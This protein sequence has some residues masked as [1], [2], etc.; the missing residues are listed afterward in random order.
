MPLTA[1]HCVCYRYE[2]SAAAAIFTLLE[3]ARNTHD[4]AGVEGAIWCLA[5]LSHLCGGRSLRLHAPHHEQLLFDTLNAAATPQTT[6][7]ILLA[8]S[9]LRAAAADPLSVRRVARQLKRVQE[10]F[11]SDNNDVALLAC[12]VVANVEQYSP[13]AHTMPTAQCALSTQCR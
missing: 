12:A 13:G 10:L 9:A 5:S 8:L 6:P 3:H 4:D 1:A 2:A 7:S 11:R